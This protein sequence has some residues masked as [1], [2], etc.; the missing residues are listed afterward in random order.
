MLC[1]VCADK[2]TE[3]LRRVL[4]DLTLRD[5]GRHPQL[6]KSKPT[7]TVTVPASPTTRAS[8]VRAPAPAPATIART[9]GIAR[10]TV[11]DT[12]GN[13]TRVVEKGARLPATHLASFLLS[14]G[15]AHALDTVS[16]VM[17]GWERSAEPP[18]T[19][20]EFAAAVDGL[21]VAFNTAAHQL[22]HET[23]VHSW[24]GKSKYHWV[25]GRRDAAVALHE[26]VAA[27]THLQSLCDRVSSR[28]AARLSTPPPRFHALD[29][30]DLTGARKAM[31][32]CGQFRVEGVLRRGSGRVGML[33]A[34]TQSLSSRVQ[35]VRL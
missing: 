5:N 35:A 19:V 6:S 29:S 10:P 4:A 3:S 18:R 12:V 31:A 20:C 2:D 1:H 32:L 21:C 34:V 30:V 13:A 16:A 14:P 17:D 28:W 33:G 8:A 9:H 27:S 22:D 15:L 24:T 25:T 23:G 11:E 7:G 26:L